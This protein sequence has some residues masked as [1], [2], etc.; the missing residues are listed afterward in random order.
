LVELPE[1][2]FGAIKIVG[3]LRLRAHLSIELLD[4]GGASLGKTGIGSV[5]N[6]RQR[7]AD[8]FVVVKR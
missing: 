5:Y 3:I 6:G 2:A 4:C 1:A 7:V 8:S